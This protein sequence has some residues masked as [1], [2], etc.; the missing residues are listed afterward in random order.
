MS[1]CVCAC[2]RACVCVCVCVRAWVEVGEQA[3]PCYCQDAKTCCKEVLLYTCCISG[4]VLCYFC[5]LTSVLGLSSH[6]RHTIKLFSKDISIK[7]LKYQ[8]SN[9]T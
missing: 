2:V 6:G 5:A 8:V 9:G 4:S 1:V 3:M 7:C